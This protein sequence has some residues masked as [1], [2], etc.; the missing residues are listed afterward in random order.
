MTIGPVSPLSF[1]GSPLFL[2][3]YNTVEAF[4]ETNGLSSGDTDYDS[5]GTYLNPPGGGLE[6]AGGS[7]PEPDTGAEPEN[8]AQGLIDRILKWAESHENFDPSFVKSMQT[9]FEDK[10]FLTDGQLKALQNIITKW[11]V[12]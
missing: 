6:P 12:E 3:A 7:E 5:G 4:L 11:H 9:Q 1:S 10:G 2:N 8:E